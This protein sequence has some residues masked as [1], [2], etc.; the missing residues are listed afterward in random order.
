MPKKITQ[1]GID[2]CL[3]ILEQMP[4]FLTSLSEKYSEEHLSTAPPRE[5]SAVE[6][7]AH[8]RSSAEVWGYTIYAMIV[9][10]SPTL[11]Y[12]HPRDWDKKQAYKKLMV[13]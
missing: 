11:E 8:I 6:I 1:K 3:Q 12:I 4:L 13:K 5:W 7:L 10:D 2:D 9:L